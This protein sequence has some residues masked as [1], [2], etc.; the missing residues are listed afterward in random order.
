MAS[1]R[2]DDAPILVQ[3]SLACRACL[4]GHVDWALTGDDAFEAQVEISCREC[5][6]RRAVS[7]TRDQALRLALDGRRS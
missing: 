5:G 7:L 2:A 4:S 1:F 6:Y 3:A